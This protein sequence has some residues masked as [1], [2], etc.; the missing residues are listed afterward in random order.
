MWVNDW[1]IHLQSRINHFREFLIGL[2]I[3]MNRISRGTHFEII[4]YTNPFFPS[5]Q[6]SSFETSISGETKFPNIDF[7]V[8]TRVGE[9]RFYSLKPSP[10]KVDL[11]LKTGF[12]F[13]F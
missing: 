5:R 3:M 11:Q 2:D 4:Y 1:V 13:G 9:L 7:E 10:L 6:K 8:K 12:L